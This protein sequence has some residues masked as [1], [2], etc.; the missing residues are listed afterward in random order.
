M[1]SGRKQLIMNSCCI[2][3][4]RGGFPAVHVPPD[5]VWTVP[6]GKVSR[7]EGEAKAM[8]AALGLEFGK[9]QTARN[10]TL[11]IYIYIFWPVVGSELMWIKQCH[12]SPI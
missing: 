8:E 2:S 9:K 6:P 11:I 5:P 4:L 12:K 1:L 10:E 3:Y 7:V